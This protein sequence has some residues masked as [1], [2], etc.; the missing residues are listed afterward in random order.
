MGLSAE[1]VLF[2]ELGVVGV[3]A[4]KKLTEQRVLT[5]ALMHYEKMASRSANSLALS[6]FSM[7]DTT[8]RADGGIDD[9]NRPVLIY[10][11]F[12]HR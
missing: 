11:L 9:I 3:R 2:D 7:M 4:G 1:R 10:W 8:T 5:L 12:C 6:L